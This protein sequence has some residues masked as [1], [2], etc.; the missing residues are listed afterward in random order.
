VASDGNEDLQPNDVWFLLTRILQKKHKSGEPLFSNIHALAYFSPRMQ[1]QKSQSKQP[2]IFWF[3]GCR[4]PDDQQMATCLNELYT[5]WPQYV[6]RA[7][8][9]AVRHLD[10][11][12]EDLR[13]LG[14]SPR[15]PK[16]QVD[17]IKRTFTEPQKTG[18]EPI[19]FKGRQ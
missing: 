13:F 19:G 15:M 1:V 11:T 10:G 4:Q 6:A 9:I 2:A 14:V 3:S 8:G 5:A 17:N 18:A 16:I 12:P 7:Q